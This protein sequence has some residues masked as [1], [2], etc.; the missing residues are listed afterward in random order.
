MHPQPLFSRL[1]GFSRIA[2]I[3]NDMLATIWMHGWPTRK[4]EPL[5]CISLQVG[6]NFTGPDV[7]T[8]RKPNG[9]P[10]EV[11]T[12]DL[13]RDATA[14]A[15]AGQPG[16]YLNDPYALAVDDQVGFQY[17]ILQAKRV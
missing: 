6:P 16:S 14:H 15:A 8:Q 7:V 3:A 11:H 12:L 10:H 17:T 1:E 9:H 4:V 2:A 5:A 13:G